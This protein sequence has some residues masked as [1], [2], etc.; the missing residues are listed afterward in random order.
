M[1]NSIQIITV[2][3]KIVS[4]KGDILFLTGDGFRT[5]TMCVFEIDQAGYTFKSEYIVPAK[6]MNGALIIC[7]MPDMSLVGT[8]DIIVKASLSNNL[9]LVSNSG[10]RLKVVEVSPKGFYMHGNKIIECPEGSY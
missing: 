2:Y 8:A 7:K 4:S 10:V 5:G 1:S 9:R 3:P 6:I